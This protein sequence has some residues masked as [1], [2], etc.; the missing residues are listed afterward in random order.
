MKSLQSWSY[1]EPTSLIPLMS[2]CLTYL[3]LGVSDSPSTIKRHKINANCQS[4]DGRRSQ[5]ILFPKGRKARCK[6]ELG[7]V[8]ETIRVSATHGFIFELSS[9]KVSAS[10][11]V[12]TFWYCKSYDI[13]RK[14]Y[15]YCSVNNSFFFPNDSKEA[16]DKVLQLRYHNTSVF[17]PFFINSRG[18][19]L[20]DFSSLGRGQT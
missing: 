10:E 8:I 19:S 13:P 7:N 4:G 5:L 11:V 12:V 17:S 1:Q 15:I 20:L 18:Y 16:M 9:F 2:L 6:A 14:I 3:H